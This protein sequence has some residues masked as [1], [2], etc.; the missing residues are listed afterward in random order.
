MRPGLAAIVGVL[1]AAIGGGAAATN[2]AAQTAYDHAF[3]AIDG[4]P[5]PLAQYRG[6]VMLVVNTASFCGFTKQY[7]GLQTLHDT[8]DTRGLV[9]IGVPTGDFGGQEYG[10]NQETKKFCEGAFGITFPL[11]AQSHV[12][13]SSQ[14]PF[15]GW[16][17]NVLGAAQAP[18]WNFHKYLVGR[19]GKLVTAFGT[20]TEPTDPAVLKAIEAELAK[21]TPTASL[22]P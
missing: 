6:K 5:L 10:S 7:Q 9:V 11:T 21:P 15:Y 18:W 22:A 20:R 17:A 8:Y 3:E 19:D 16:A 14:H 12:R 1:S 4:K 13:G 2:V